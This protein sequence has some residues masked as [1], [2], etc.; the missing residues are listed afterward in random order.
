MNFQTCQN[1]VTIGY[2]Q[3]AAIAFGF[4]LIQIAFH[5]FIHPRTPINL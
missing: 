1:P 4:S 3:S 2:Y 5:F